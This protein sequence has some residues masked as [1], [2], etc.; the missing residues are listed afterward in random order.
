MTFDLVHVYITTI[1]VFGIVVELGALVYLAILV[2]E[3]RKKMDADDAA[4]YLQSRRV[5]EVLRE[6]RSEFLRQ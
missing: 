2:R 1:S 6:M 5:Q 3:S 4:L